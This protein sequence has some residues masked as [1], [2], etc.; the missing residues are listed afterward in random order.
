MGAAAEIAALL[1]RVSRFPASSLML[2]V[3][4]DV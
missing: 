4:I 3:N 1:V 2:R